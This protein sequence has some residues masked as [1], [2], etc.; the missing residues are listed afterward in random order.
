MPLMEL[1][2]A[3]FHRENLQRMRAKF[4]PNED[5]HNRT[6]CHDAMDE[7]CVLWTNT[8]YFPFPLEL[9]PANPTFRR[10]E[11]DMGYFMDTSVMTA[12]KYSEAR[13]Y[14]RTE[15]DVPTHF[16]DVST[17]DLFAEVITVSYT[18]LTL[19]TTPYV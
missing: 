2:Q 13:E 15:F 1:K 10:F 7:R 9:C 12:R 11:S 8:I 14:C 18:H 17:V 19:P 16:P 5:K 4:I 6:Q 3:L